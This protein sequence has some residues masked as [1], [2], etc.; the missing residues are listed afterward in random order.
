MLSYP[1]CRFICKQ[2]AFTNTHTIYDDTSLDFV[3]KAHLSPHFP[4]LLSNSDHTCY[5]K[6]TINARMCLNTH[7]C[8]ICV[9]NINGTI[10]PGPLV[11]YVEQVYMLKR[12]PAEAYFHQGGVA[13]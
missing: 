6:Q 12:V 13:N 5:K 1:Q 9:Y 3:L 2:N 11:V 4:T 7:A 8:N 10:T